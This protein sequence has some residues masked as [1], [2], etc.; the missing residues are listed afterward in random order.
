[1]KKIPFLLIT[2]AGLWAGGFVIPH[3]GETKCYDNTKEIVCPSVGERF[4]G[5]DGNYIQ[6]PLRYKD[7]G[8][9]PSGSAPQNM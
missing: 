1:M 8:D 4:Y 7:N 5:Q 3:T 9:V 6:N 2:T